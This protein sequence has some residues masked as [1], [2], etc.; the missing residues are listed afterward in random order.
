ML[1]NQNNNSTQL[2]I[3]AYGLETVAG[4]QDFALFGAIAARLCSASEDSKHPVPSPS[5]EG[6]DS[7]LTAPIPALTD[8]EPDDRMLICLT[9]AI[10]NAAQHLL[11]T[12]LEQ[13]RHLV[14][15]VLP[16]DETKRSQFID[17]KLWQESIKNELDSFSDL[18]FAFLKSDANVVKHIQS[19]CAKLSD[20]KLES[21]LFAGSDSLL[22][23]LTLDDLIENRR[24]C[25]AALSDGV[26][27]G[28]AAACVIIQ[29]VDV[30]S[31]HNRAIIKGL[32][33]ADEPNSGKA[34]QKLLVG[35]GKAIKGAATMAG[36][37]TDTI[38]CVVRHGVTERRTAL[39]W[40]QTTNAIWPNKLPE[41]LRVAYQ[42]GEL[43]EPPKLKPRKMPEELDVSLSIGEVG[44]ASIPLGLVLACARFD[45]NFPSVKNCLV[46]EAN[47]YPFRGVIMLENPQAEQ[48]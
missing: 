18:H 43:D 42:V 17:T 32:S 40:L 14:L 25:S 15:I 4:N 27:P 7:A 9:S 28:E 3:T 22:D 21:I 1:T 12:N 10:G 33:H 48:Q 41:Q 39:E 38:D 36:Q 29:S 24:L 37:H 19:V 30:S 16:A 47:D 45:F 23:Q 11:D 34:D 6:F 13:K 44:A 31:K 5:G 46:F 2:A 8:L 26:V 35:L 20:N